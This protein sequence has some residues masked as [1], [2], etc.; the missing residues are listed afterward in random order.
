MYFICIYFIAMYISMQK[1]FVLFISNLSI[2]GLLDFL[3]L[4]S[5]LCR[6]LADEICIKYSVKLLDLELED[7]NIADDM[8]CKVTENSPLNGMNVTVIQYF[9]CALILH[10]NQLL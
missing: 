9:Q 7:I 3:K 8:E 1:Y 10:H 6:I 2:P 4:Y 5:K